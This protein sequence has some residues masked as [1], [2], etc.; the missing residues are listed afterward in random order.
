MSDE[1]LNLKA[2]T[3]L[4]KEFTNIVDSLGIEGSVL[5]EEAKEN[6]Q[7]KYQIDNP[8]AVKDRL[9]ALGTM[10]SI[11]PLQQVDYY[12]L[13]PDQKPSYLTESL[14]WREE[15]SFVD[16]A[17]A[18]K[19]EPPAVGQL[20]YKTN[21]HSEDSDHGRSM[22]WLYVADEDT[23]WA[24]LTKIKEIRRG[25]DYTP[26]SVTKKRTTFMLPLNNSNQNDSVIIHL[27]ENVQLTNR[28][29]IK[30]NVTHPVGDFL[31]ISIANNLADQLTVVTKLLGIS[32]Q[33]FN[34]P[35]IDKEAFI[36]KL[37]KTKYQPNRIPTEPV[38]LD[39][40]KVIHKP[41]YYNATSD[42]F[43]VGIDPV[44]IGKLDINLHDEAESQVLQI[45]Q[46]LDR[47][48]GGLD[49]PI[50]QSSSDSGST[51]YERFPHHDGFRNYP[52]IRSLFKSAVLYRKRW[53]P[54]D[55]RIAFS[56]VQ[57][58]DNPQDVGI[59]IH[60]FSNHNMFEE[61]LQ[62]HHK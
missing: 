19:P 62:R 52:T 9:L 40:L 22:R 7:Y 57:F 10:Q 56:R 38:E 58:S 27:D 17:H 32:G 48:H 59:F 53:Q 2:E 3:A 15:R 31:E 34:V 47:S 33:P 43:M 16:Y 51:T 55:R 5:K 8:Q 54:G 46:D 60:L 13:Y 35:Y 20:I 6:K 11:G 50:R 61:W 44:I 29:T 25:Q 21:P 4:E 42:K 24:V 49:L 39:W 36:N 41:Y 18:D 45:C 23:Q 14:C 28:S 26:Y 37:Y 30:G 12:F 1:S